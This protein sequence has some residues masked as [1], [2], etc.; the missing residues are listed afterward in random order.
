MNTG[1]LNNGKHRT[2]NIEHRTS[3]IEHP[4][5]VPASFLGCWLLDVPQVIRSNSP[6]P[7]L[8]RP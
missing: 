1:A 4:M 8:K 6:Q 2:S 5:G 3:N 7:F